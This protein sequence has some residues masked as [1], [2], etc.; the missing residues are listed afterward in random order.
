M[1]KVLVV[2][3]VYP[4]SIELE[5]EVIVERIKSN[6]PYGVELLRYDVEPVAFGLNALRLYLA[7]PEETEGGTEPIEAAISSTEGVS[8]VD[9]ELVHR[10]SL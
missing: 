6:L 3:K 4:E 2:V 7:M 1:A 9:V 5:P 8:N 10:V